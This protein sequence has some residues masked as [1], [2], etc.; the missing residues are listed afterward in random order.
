MLAAA[1]EM[2]LYSLAD[3]HIISSRSGYGHV[4]AMW[5]RRWHQQFSVE[6]ARNMHR[7]CGIHNYEPE[8]PNFY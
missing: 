3:Y 7:K 5:S 4:G 6:K 8:L 1:G 2:Y